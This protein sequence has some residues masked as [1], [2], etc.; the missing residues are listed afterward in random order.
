SLLSAMIN[1]PERRVASA[2]ALSLLSFSLDNARAAL[3]TH[4]AD[5]EF[6]MLFANALAREKPGKYLEFLEKT[7]REKREPEHW[8]GG[9]IPWGESW[10]ILFAYAQDHP[11]DARQ[12]KLDSVLGA[13]ESPDY[14]S[15]SEPRDLYALYA[16]LGM[17][18]RADAFRD[19][20]RK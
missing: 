4:V 15:S 6:G 18:K 10:D 17:A 19:Q 20:A 8:W 16:R 9:S 13:L 2:A 12:G 7:I 14:F 3:E 11:D 1:D 5:P